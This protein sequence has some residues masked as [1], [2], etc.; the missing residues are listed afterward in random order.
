MIFLIEIFVYR[1]PI[2]DEQWALNVGM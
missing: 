1:Q 2:L